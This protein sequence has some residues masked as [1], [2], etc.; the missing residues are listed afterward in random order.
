MNLNNNDVNHE[1]LEQVDIVS[2]QAADNKSRLQSEKQEK[3]KLRERWTLIV[4]IL[5]V[6]VALTLTSINLILD[7]SRPDPQLYIVTEDRLNIEV[8]ASALI[9]RN[10]NLISANR[11]GILRPYKNSGEKVAIGDL[12]ARIFPESAQATLDQIDELDRQISERQVELISGSVLPEDDGIEDIYLEYDKEL[13]DYVNQIRTVSNT[14]SDNN[15]DKNIDE[16]ITLKLRERSQELSTLS[17]GDETITNLISSRNNLQQSLEQYASNIYSPYSGVVSYLVDDYS[18]PL[19]ESRLG[20]LTA[21]VIDADHDNTSKL[22]ETIESGAAAFNIID[23]YSQYINVALEQETAELF[24]VGDYYVL[25]FPE[26][27]ISLEDANLAQMSQANE[28]GL[29]VL[30]FR[31]RRNLE[32]LADIRKTNVSINLSSTRG[33]KAPNN[34]ILENESTGEF[35]VMVMRSGYVYR[36]KINRGPR[37]NNYSI[38][39]TDEDAT[40]VLR[41]GSIIIQNPEVVE[42]GESIRR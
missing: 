14:S 39:S 24:T 26:Q 4:V 1:N 5:F 37:D 3:Q 23:E 2:S 22:G 19:N 6:I 17:L 12:V 13:E 42:S 31:S 34:A 21:Q 11:S 16:K 35:Y 29:V 7:N 40:Y 10:E 27:N 20:S 8:D 41:D 9:L 25:D 38:I 36:Q 30:S 28:D 18:K 32:I 33:L 15:F